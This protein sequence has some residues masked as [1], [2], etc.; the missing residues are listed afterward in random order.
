MDAKLKRFAEIGVFCASKTLN[1]ERFRSKLI[2]FQASDQ[3]HKG[4]RFSFGAV[5][6]F[7]STRPESSVPKGNLE[8]EPEAKGKKLAN[9]Q[10]CKARFTQVLGLQ[11]CHGSVQKMTKML[12]DLEFGKTRDHRE[13]A[14]SIIVRRMTMM[15]SGQTCSEIRCSSTMSMAVMSWT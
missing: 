14:T 5:F 11:K 15:R 6:F 7:S 8:H 2:P 12:L 9:A 4:N 1:M 13:T 10:G 3:H